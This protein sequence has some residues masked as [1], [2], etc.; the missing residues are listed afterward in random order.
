MLTVSLLSAP[1]LQGTPSWSWPG[2]CGYMATSVPGGVLG[3]W[4]EQAARWGPGQWEV[5]A[6]QTH[7]QGRSTHTM[8]SPLL[9]SGVLP[10]EARDHGEA[11]VFIVSTESSSTAQF[12]LVSADGEGHLGRD[13][14][15]TKP[16]EAMTDLLGHE[17]NVEGLFS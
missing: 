17:Q 14:L 1:L 12:C 15:S 10:Q 16:D 2:L 6:G 8:H 13:L 7:S 3:Q 9:F 4:E 11:N 5:Q